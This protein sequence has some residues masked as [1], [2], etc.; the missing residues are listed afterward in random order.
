MNLDGFLSFL[1]KGYSRAPE[2]FCIDTMVLKYTMHTIGLISGDKP[3]AESIGSEEHGPKYLVEN[4]YC[5]Q[6][7]RFKCYAGS[8]NISLNGENLE[9]I[10]ISASDDGKEAD[11]NGYV[12]IFH[13]FLIFG[14]KFAVRHYDS[15]I[16]YMYVSGFCRIPD[17]PE[18]LTAQGLR[19]KFLNRFT[20]HMGESLMSSGKANVLSEDNVESA[21]DA[22]GM[23]SDMASLAYK[24][25]WAE[26]FCSMRRN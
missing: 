12:T 3:V 5:L 23:A 19:E 2:S 4:G 21:N 22:L 24:V 25:M 13:D 16:S 26:N 11:R 1:G 14:T 10:T 6:N 9:L 7:E 15:Y 8:I 20:R 17:Y 18:I